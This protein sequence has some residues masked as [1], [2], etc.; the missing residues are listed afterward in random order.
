MIRVGF[1]PKE[2]FASSGEFEI[3]IKLWN[4]TSAN[5]KRENPKLSMSGDM[6]CK[7]DELFF[8]E[9]KTV[10]AKTHDADNAAENSRLSG[11][12]IKSINSLRPEKEVVRKKKESDPENESATGQ[13]IER[14]YRY[15]DR[16]MNQAEFD[17]WY[18]SLPEKEKA[19]I[20]PKV[21]TITKTED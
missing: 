5:W 11:L 9:I 21:E 8:H 19:D 15:L 2:K 18:K 7:Y 20:M 14:R 13:E 1:I 17:I 10:Y 16:E 3:Y 12:L 6:I 4:E